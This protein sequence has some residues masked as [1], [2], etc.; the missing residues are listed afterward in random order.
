MINTA[1]AAKSAG[2]NNSK[3]DNTMILDGLTCKIKVSGKTVTANREIR[4][5]YFGDYDMRGLNIQETIEKNL[6]DDFHIRA[7]VIRY[8]LTQEQ[9][10]EYHLP[11][12]PAK[13]TDSMA[14]GWIEKNGNVAWELDALEPLVLEGII[15]KVIQ[16]QIDVAILSNRTNEIQAAKNWMHT[17]TKEY[18]EA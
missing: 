15:E 7:K 8:A 9:I 6:L 18:L 1:D 3:K 2:V 4:I 17:T 11:P 16:S 13:A 5:L 14:K 10:D 12:A